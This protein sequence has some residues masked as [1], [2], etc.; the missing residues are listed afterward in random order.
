MTILPGPI[1]QIGYVVTDLDQAMAGWLELGVGPWFVLR[2]LPLRADYR[3]EPC[4]T[5][6]SLASANSGEMQ[7]EL[8]QQLDTTPSIFT[9]FLAAH[10][11]GL[12]QLAYWTTDFAATMSDVEK[13]GWPVVWSGGE[14]Y[15]VR[16]AYVEPPDAPAAGHRDLRTHRGDG[17][18]RD[19]HPRCRGRVGRQRSRSATCS[20]FSA[21]HLSRFITLSAAA[22]CSSDTHNRAKAATASVVVTPSHH[23]LDLAGRTAGQRPGRSPASPS[24]KDARG[25]SWSTSPMRSASAA[26]RISARA[27]KQ[28]RLAEADQRDEPLGAAPRGHDLQRHLVEADLDVVGGE[29]DVGRHRDLGAAAQRVP[30]ERGDGRAGKP[31]I[32]SQIERIRHAIAPASRSVRSAL[33]SLRSPPGHECPVAG[34]GDDQRGRALR[35]VERLVQLVHRLQRD[36]VAGVRAVDGDDRQAVIQLEVDH[37]AFSVCGIGILSS[38]E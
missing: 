31:A 28:Q 16:F 35:P 9:E 26:S 19:I 21:D 17:C 23:A 8:I 34:A 15:G 10:G 38:G 36:G 1:R 30:V 24:S 18:E 7:I 32:R 20:A 13:A 25:N 12:H 3:G 33:S 2:G 5:T 14:G 11:P 29:P 37:R 22:Q 6:L 27:R 4:E